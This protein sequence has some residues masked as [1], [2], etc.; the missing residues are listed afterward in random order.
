ML[1]RDKSA[2]KLSKNKIL[3]CRQ[4]TEPSG[5]IISTS[6]KFNGTMNIWNNE[7]KKSKSKSKSRLKITSPKNRL[8]LLN[9]PTSN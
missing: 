7:V 5:T 2:N 8:N 1:S 4:N 6:Q 3:S 9:L